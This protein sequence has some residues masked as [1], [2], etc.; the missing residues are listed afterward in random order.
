MIRGGG[1]GGSGVLTIFESEA[2]EVGQA[3]VGIKVLM[4]R[5]SEEKEE[6]ERKC[7][8]PNPKITQAQ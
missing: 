8:T 5:I 4:G 1:D 2:E 6:R 7:N 3:F